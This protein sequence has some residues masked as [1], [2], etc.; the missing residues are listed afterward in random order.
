MPGVVSMLKAIYHWTAPEC[1][2][3][4]ICG[5]RLMGDK[6]ISLHFNVKLNMVSWT[7]IPFKNQ[8]TIFHHRLPDLFPI[9]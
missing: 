2:K 8:V 3:L 9:D 4:I 5:N 6:D 1:G 7:P